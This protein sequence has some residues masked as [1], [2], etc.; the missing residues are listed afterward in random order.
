M[1]HI[2]LRTPTKRRGRH[3]PCV[4]LTRLS[5]AIHVLLRRSA[6]TFSQ[7][8]IACVSAHRA[9]A[10]DPTL[11]KTTRSSSRPS[12]IRQSARATY[13]LTQ[14]ESGLK[15]HRVVQQNIAT[16][17][18]VTRGDSGQENDPPTCTSLGRVIAIERGGRTITA[19][20]RASPNCRKTKFHASPIEAGVHAAF[21]RAT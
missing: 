14:G 9:P 10:C 20:G 16:G 7:G 4:R 21:L 11:L 18:V 6:R 13:L 12:P 2:S 3:S 17:T 15:V 8:V 19:V 1:Q 5:S